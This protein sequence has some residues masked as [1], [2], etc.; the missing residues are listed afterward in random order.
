METKSSDL[1]KVFLGSRNKTKILFQIKN[2]AIKSW[3]MTKTLKGDII[4]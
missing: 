3:I 1:F 2:I 4:K